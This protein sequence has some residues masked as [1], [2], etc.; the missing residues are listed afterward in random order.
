MTKVETTTPVLQ[1]K[2]ISKRFDTTQALDD[3]SLDLY[4]GEIHALMG[5]NGR[6][7]INPD[8]ESLRVSTIRRGGIMAGWQPDP[9]GSLSGCT[10][11]R[12]RGHLPGSLWSILIE[13]AENIFITHGATDFS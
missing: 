3:V 5:E 12:H 1:V 11:L 8:Q 2:R 9:C 10:G 4:P 6:W 13:C 7:Q